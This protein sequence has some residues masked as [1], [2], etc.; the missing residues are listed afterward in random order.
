MKKKINNQLTYFSIFST[1]FEQ[2]LQVIYIL[3]ILSR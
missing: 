3:N 1:I 2:L